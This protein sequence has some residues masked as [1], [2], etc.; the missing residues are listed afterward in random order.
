MKKG[1]KK[2]FLNNWQLSCCFTIH[3]SVMQRIKM[4]QSMPK[5]V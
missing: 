4:F 1:K 2:A 3:F 5:F